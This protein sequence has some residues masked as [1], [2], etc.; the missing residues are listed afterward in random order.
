MTPVERL[1]KEF[2]KI[3][4]QM[5]YLCNR[6]EE[7]EMQNE[8]LLKEWKKIVVETDENDPIPIAA[9]DSNEIQVAGGYRVR[10]TPSTD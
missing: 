5:D 3:R 6:V 9:I 10:L 4:K 8:S 1:D 2:S 7:Q